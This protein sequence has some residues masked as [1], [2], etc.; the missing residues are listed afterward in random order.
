MTNPIFGP[1][2]LTWTGLQENQIYTLTLSEDLVDIYGHTLASEIKINF[3]YSL[4]PFYASWGK[5]KTLLNTYGIRNISDLQLATIVF[6]YS[7]KAEEMYGGTIPES[8]YSSVY[9]WVMYSVIRQLLEGALI[10]TGMDLG[11]GGGY[12]LGDLTIRGPSLAWANYVAP[13]MQLIQD[14]INQC[15]DAFVP[16]FTEGFVKSALKSEFYSNIDPIINR[17]RT[18]DNI[19]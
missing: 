8:L 16:N 15:Q 9:C 12:T 3:I 10:K 2:D 18:W 11:G 5:I 14:R 19:L 17:D 13:L 6:D 4:N 1:V 7:I